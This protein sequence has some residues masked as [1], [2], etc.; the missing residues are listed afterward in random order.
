MAVYSRR[1]GDL[2]FSQQDTLRSTALSSGMAKTW[3][4]Q[5]KC[6][7]QLAT[8]DIQEFW[9]WLLILQVLLPDARPLGSSNSRRWHRDWQYCMWFRG[10]KGSGGCAWQWGVWCDDYTTGGRSVSREPMGAPGIL[11]SQAELIVHTRS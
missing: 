2:G 4:V 9:A 3:L 6:E 8:R 5:P 7:S 10:R 1:L 11:R